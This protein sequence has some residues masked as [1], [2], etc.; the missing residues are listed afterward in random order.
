MFSGVLLS[1][2][3]DSW[4]SLDDML[5]VLDSTLSRQITA[6]HAGPAGNEHTNGTGNRN[7]VSAANEEAYPLEVLLGGVRE[8]RG[9]VTAGRLLCKHGMPLTVQSIKD[10]G[11][12]E[13]GTI[14]RQ[15]LVWAQK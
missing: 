11:V 1:T 12:D 6:V 3:T 7:R 4:E 13:A 9:F 2:R 10:C 15:L 5:A 8:V 14:F